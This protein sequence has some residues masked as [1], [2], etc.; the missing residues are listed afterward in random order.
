[1]GNKPTVLIDLDGTLFWFGTNKLTREAREKVAEFIEKG[2]QII[3]ITNRPKADVPVF[4]L[5]EMAPG[6]G[7]V[8]NSNSPRIMI[9]D[10][11]TTH[12]ANSK[13]Y[14]VRRNAGI[15]RVDVDEEGTNLSYVERDKRMRLERKLK[16][17]ESNGGKP[18]E[19]EE[20]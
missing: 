17:L 18:T 13:L 15:A 10:D 6:C 9:D 5:K 8:F 12:R 1:M 19:R 3:F 7:F 2:F 16:A 14:I 20:E 11:G 4:M